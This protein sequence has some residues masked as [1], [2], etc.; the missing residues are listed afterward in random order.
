VKHVILCYGQFYYDL[1]EKRDELKKAVYFSL[2]Q[3]HVIIRIEQLAPMPHNQLGKI[4]AK[5]K[6]AKVTW[7]QE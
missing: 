7:A 2:I 1:K 4:L 5:Y 3:D 6:N